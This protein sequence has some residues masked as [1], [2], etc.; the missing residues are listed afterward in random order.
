MRKDICTGMFAAS[1]MIAETNSMLCP[2]SIVNSEIFAYCQ[3]THVQP[4]HFL[5]QLPSGYYSGVVR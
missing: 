2:C 1:N 4:F 5:D 3:R